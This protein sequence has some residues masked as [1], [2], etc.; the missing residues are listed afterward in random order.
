MPVLEKSIED[1]LVR[2][3]KEA[4]G[5][6]I[7]IERRAHWPDRLIAMPFHGLHLVETKKPKDGRLSEGQKILHANLAAIGTKVWII[8]TKQQVDD[9]I[10]SNTL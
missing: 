1:Y 9:F 10:R 5:E 6:Q 3:V 7:K 2:R 4:G 8:W